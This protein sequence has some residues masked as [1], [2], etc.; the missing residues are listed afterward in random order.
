MDKETSRVDLIKS[1]I[2]I[3]QIHYF[4]NK[5]YKNE[6]KELISILYDY[7]DKLIT[8]S[9]SEINAGWVSKEIDIWW[10]VKKSF[11][12]MWDAD[13]RKILEAINWISDVDRV[14][15]F[16]E[17]GDITIWSS[18]VWEFKDNKYVKKE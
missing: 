8:L 4:K 10:W 9:L 14:K 15:K 7:K 11:N 18:E 17:A 2:D 13:K 16:G 1:F 12:S 3:Y 6:L 5:Y